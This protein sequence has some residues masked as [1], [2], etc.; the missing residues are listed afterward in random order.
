MLHKQV[1]L[2]SPVTEVNNVSFLLLIWGSMSWACYRAGICSL[3]LWHNI[4]MFFA[5]VSVLVWS[6]KKFNLFENICCIFHA[7]FLHSNCWM[8]EVF[9]LHLRLKAKT[10]ILLTKMCLWWLS[11]CADQLLTL[12]VAVPDAEVTFH[13]MFGV[14]F[15]AWAPA[16]SHVL[17]SSV[18]PCLEV[19]PCMGS[20]C[21]G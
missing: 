4:V 9:R 6:F 14:L 2:H 10:F 13:V 19:L 20:L 18:W 21:C 3:F 7:Y 1:F 16:G 11:Y 15:I 12:C 8:K 17:C 5:C